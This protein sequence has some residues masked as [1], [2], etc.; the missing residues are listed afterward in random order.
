MDANY[1]LEFT[2]GDDAPY[3]LAASPEVS[4]DG[5]CFAA[6]GSGLYRSRDGGARWERLRASSERVTTA[7]AVSPSFAQ[8]RSVF[9]AVK[10]GVLRS[11]DGGDNWFTSAFAAPPPLFSSLI[12]SPAFERDG[13]LLAAT[14]E[15]GV[16]SSTDRGV[17]WQAWNFGLFDLNV[18]CLALSPAWSADETAFAGT[19]TGL[20][21]ST[22]GGRAWRHTGF[23]TALAPVLS[24][25]C[26]AGEN[27]GKYTVFA[28]TEAN[29]LL[30]S[31]DM[32]E[33]WGAVDEDLL[34]GAVN[35]LQVVE[36]AAGASLY[37]LTERGV[38]ES[39]DGGRTWGEALRT[40]DA[41]ST[42]LVLDGAIL[43]GMPG[44]GLRRDKLA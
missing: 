12:V 37:A 30:F 24:L 3:G 27:C 15:D 31:G 2:E 6:C 11:S 9:A 44:K 28:G 21:R 17:R 39:G 18:L 25:A 19:E 41:P 8:D 29:G 40:A 7:L 14:L 20:Y 36:R 35:Q 16:F 32:G 1:T 13:F 34:R 4:R 26:I 23:P 10:G 5:I 33:T 43:L 38:V 42:M 22:N